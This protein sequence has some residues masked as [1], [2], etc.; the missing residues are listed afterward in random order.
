MTLFEGNKLLYFC[1]AEIHWFIPSVSA[2]Q[3]PFLTGIL[4]HCVTRGQQKGMT[5]C[6]LIQT[7]PTS[8]LTRRR[9]ES[10][11]P[12][13][14]FSRKKNASFDRYWKISAETVFLLQSFKHFFTFCHLS[15]RGNVMY[16]LMI[17]LRI[18]CVCRVR[19][20]YAAILYSDSFM[21]R[22]AFILV[23]KT[24]IIC[25]D[26][27]MSRSTGIEALPTP[28]NQSH[29]IIIHDSVKSPTVKR[30]LHLGSS[31]QKSSPATKQGCCNCKCILVTYN[32]YIIMV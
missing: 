11:F 16:T 10:H 18:L 28:Y 24:R 2:N 30:D 7:N 27:N 19:E 17:P 8:S 23:T 32:L 3:N 4:D 14:L 25:N 31:C 1:W 26:C 5:G 15:N 29:G 12:S 9:T 13:H 21:H 6:D 20:F 22:K